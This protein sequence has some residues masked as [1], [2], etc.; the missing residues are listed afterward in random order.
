MHVPYQFM[1]ALEDERLRVAARDH[2][3]T[4]ARRAHRKTRRIR[5]TR[6]NP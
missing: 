4:T 5:K 1:K 2:Q 6:R 3:V